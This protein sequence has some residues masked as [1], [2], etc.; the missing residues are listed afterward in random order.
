MAADPRVAPETDPLL[1]TG[2][3]PA[4]SDV[5]PGTRVLLTAF[6]GLTLLAV[7]ALL[8]SPER[9]QE[10]FAWS[11]KMEI[12][13]AWLGAAYASGSVLSL[14]ALRRRR[15]DEIRVAVV[16]VGVFTALTLVATL[17]HAH[18]LNLLHGEEAGQFAAWVWFAVYLVVPVACAAVVVLQE[19][20]RRP[21][22]DVGHPLPRWLARL[23]GVQGVVLAAAGAVLFLGG[24]TVH[25]H[26]EVVT[27]FWPWD[28]MPLSS[29]VIGAWL[30]AL[31]VGALLVIRQRDLTRMLVPAVTYTLFGALQLAVLVR[32]R[33]DVD[34]G[35]PWLWAYVAVCAVV[36]GTGGYGWW[37]ARRGRR[38]D[39]RE[40]TE[41][42]RDGSR[43]AVEGRVLEIC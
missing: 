30:V 16:T 28:V 23:L 3:D 17:V 38:A 27:R 34:P 15:W 5:R 33:A 31:G 7:L 39:D 2:P 29:Q 14:L 32:Y 18:R 37:A 11:I 6:S 22:P 12:T 35:D 1:R 42:A 24:L 20:G 21:A 36:T 40:G 13:A 25:H 41:A 9:A 8:V 19:V 43:D 10:A 4:E 26:S